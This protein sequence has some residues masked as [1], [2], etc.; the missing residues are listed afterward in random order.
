MGAFPARPG[1]V[2]RRNLDDRRPRFRRLKPEP[3]PEIR[4]GSPDPVGPG[5]GRLIR[6][7][8]LRSFE[9]HDLP[10]IESSS[11]MTA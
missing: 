4:D 11:P 10:E 5:G 9:F 8:S 2:F 6:F 1:R 7:F 3:L